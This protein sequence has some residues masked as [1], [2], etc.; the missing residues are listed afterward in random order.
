MALR[1]APAASAKRCHVPSRARK[2]HRHHCARASSNICAPETHFLSRRQSCDPIHSL[3]HDQRLH[4]LGHSSVYLYQVARASVD[5]QHTPAP[6]TLPCT[7]I[8]P[9]GGRHSQAGAGRRRACCSPQKVEAIR[10]A[11]LADTADGHR[12][13]RAHFPQEGT[14]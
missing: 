10:A 4:D 9:H 3:A 13:S 12:Q 11:P 8:S 1:R 6:C 14:L 5:P 2:Q 7:R